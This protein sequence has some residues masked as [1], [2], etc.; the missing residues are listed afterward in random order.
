MEIY[1]PKKVFKSIAAIGIAGALGFG[2]FGSYQRETRN[3]PFTHYNRLEV[4]LTGGFRSVGS[5]TW[6]RNHTV[7]VWKTRSGNAGA[8]LGERGS[9]TG[10]GRVSAQS[11]FFHSAG[12]DPNNATARISTISAP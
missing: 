8:Q 11:P 10:L 3:E 6:D 1:I 12:F 4:N 2:A 7:S 5:I 9:S